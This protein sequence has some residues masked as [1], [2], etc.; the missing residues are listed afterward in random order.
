M[1][2]TC[3]QGTNA[4]LFLT[5]Y[6][7]YCNPKHRIADITWG[8]GVFWSKIKHAPDLLFASDLKGGEGIFDFDFKKLPYENGYFDRVVFDP[9]YM[10]NP[11][12]P[13]VNNSYQ[14]KETTTG[15]YHKDIIE[16][17]SAGMREASRI[18]KPKC[19]LFVKCQDEIE[20]SKQYWSHIE[21]YEIALKLGFYA[22]DLFVLHQINK[23]I[24]QHKNQKHARKNHSYLW[25]FEKC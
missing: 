8:K 15:F 12:K 16:L 5:V 23:P 20:S 24:L 11:G 7:F 1:I 18:L 2:L 14:N 21:I 9:P 3:I 19:Y 4:D 25:V 10:H 6:N 13:I 22:K 17:Y